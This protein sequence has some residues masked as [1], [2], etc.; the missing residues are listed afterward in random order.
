[1]DPLANMITQLKNAG[2]ARREIVNVTYSKLKESILT[3]LKEEGFIKNFE[4]KSEKGKPVLVV[5]LLS[6]NRIPKIKGVKRI[7]KPGKR[8]YQKATDIRGVKQG[9]GALILSTPA[10][11][12]TGREAKKAKVGGEALFSIW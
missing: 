7:S 1:M 4:K 5:E 2:N 12:M 3:V 9:Y 10:G 11:I 8:I 6:L